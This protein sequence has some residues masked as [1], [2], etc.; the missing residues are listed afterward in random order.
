MRLSFLFPRPKYWYKT[1]IRNTF[2]LLIPLATSSELTCIF[3][4]FL[5]QFSALKEWPTSMLP[6]GHA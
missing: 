1:F 6:T 5:A 2:H 3:F 4:P